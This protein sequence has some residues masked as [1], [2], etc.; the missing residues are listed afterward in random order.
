M[1]QASLTERLRFYESIFGKGQL[2]RDERNFSVR[3]PICDPKDPSKKKL[4]IRTADDVTHCWTCSFSSRS[5]VP[6]IRKYGSQSKLS[7]YLSRFH[8]DK[9]AQ[10][11][12]QQVEESRLAPPKD[13]RLI[14]C[15][16]DSDPDALAVEKYLR[17]RGLTD[18]DLWYYRVAY[19]HEPIWYRR[20][21]FLSYSSSG[22][23]NYIVA[24]SIDQKKKP[25]Y[26]NCDLDKTSIVFNEINIDWSSPVS[27]CEG[28]FDMINCGSNA[29]CLLG[30]E[31]SESSLLFD[32]IVSNSTPVV[33]VLDSDTVSHK[34]PRLVKKLKE[35]DINVKIAS[36][37]EYTDPG[38]AP[39][40]FV[41]RA[42]QEAREVDWSDTFRDKLL[43]LAT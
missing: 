35:Y 21:V 31:L 12:E 34:R 29:V 4:V 24:R 6:L 2:A 26:V 32:R 41:Q 18:R 1:V 11:V 39:R 38:S 8:A 40:E 10:H 20:A 37:G 7:E 36:L 43:K 33:V 17:A 13:I 27:L 23:L 42:I 5:L 14:A 3:C 28:P 25:K 16:N 15:R 30:S 22:D 9:Q 19:S